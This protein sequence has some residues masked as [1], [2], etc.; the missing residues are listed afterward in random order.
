[1]I[2]KYQIA[3]SNH[4]HKSFQITLAAICDGVS[5][6]LRVSLLLRPAYGTLHTC[7]R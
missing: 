5:E 4:M 3:E 1:M 6:Y 7:S 2:L